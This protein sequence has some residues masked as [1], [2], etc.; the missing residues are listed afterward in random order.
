MSW[1]QPQSQTRRFRVKARGAVVRR[2]PSLT[3]PVVGELKG[4]TVVQCETPDAAGRVRVQGEGFVSLKVLEL[5]GTGHAVPRSLTPRPVLRTKTVSIKSRAGLRAFLR[6]KDQEARWANGL[7]ESTF[8][9][10]DTPYGRWVS[11]HRP[12]EDQFAPKVRTAYAQHLRDAGSLDEAMEHVSEALMD[13]P[14][15]KKARRLLGDVATAIKARAA[16]RAP[17][18]R[19]RAAALV[20]RADASYKVGDVKTALVLY[21]CLLDSMLGEDV[22]SARLIDGETIIIHARPFDAAEASKLHHFRAGC[23]SKLRRYAVAEE[24]SR[25]AL[26]LREAVPYRKR[27]STILD[28]AGQWG[29]AVVELVSLKGTHAFAIAEGRARVFEMRAMLR[30][31]Q[32]TKKHAQ[33][34]S[35]KEWLELVQTD[36]GNPLMTGR[37]LFA[38][39]SHIELQHELDRRRYRK[40]AQE[41]VAQAWVLQDDRRVASCAARLCASPF[42]SRLRKR[43]TRPYWLF[44]KRVRGSPKRPRTSA[45]AHSRGTP[46]LLMDCTPFVSTWTESWAM[47]ASAW[48]HKGA[49]SPVL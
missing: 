9:Y 31:D 6:H 21:G 26:E 24:E 12:G 35:A 40:R 4:G 22:A 39:M 46:S 29:A 33:D 20:T 18:A 17:D 44:L 43:F 30:E 48:R 27:L 49:T 36:E 45:G 28:R 3:S 7:D 23:F 41:A 38:A 8:S 47:C 11:V 37:S 19:A 1:Q 10:E 42:A 25:R 16:A 32:T 34:V 14:S 2:G 13:E 15:S 5:Y